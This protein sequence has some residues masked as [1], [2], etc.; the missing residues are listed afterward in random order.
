MVNEGE[1]G[2]NA[3]DN[4]HFNMVKDRIKAGDYLY[5]ELRSQ[6]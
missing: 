4:Y 6:P 2:L 1:G 3:A 5:V